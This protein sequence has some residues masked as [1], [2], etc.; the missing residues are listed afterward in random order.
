MLNNKY[1]LQMFNWPYSSVDRALVLLHLLG[2]FSGIRTGS[3][4]VR[5]IFCVCVCATHKMASGGPDD[6]MKLRMK[7]VSG[8][9]I[10]E[11]MNGKR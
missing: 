8:A 9:T 6:I 10:R 1:Y 4:P 5:D 2:G 3:N 11:R 7:R